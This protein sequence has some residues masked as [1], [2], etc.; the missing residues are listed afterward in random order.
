MGDFVLVEK[1]FSVGLSRPS[2]GTWLSFS[3]LEHPTS[4]WRVVVK[5]KKKK[6]TNKKEKPKNEQ[7]QQLK[8]Y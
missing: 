1:A 8:G 3:W 6:Q 4:L 7:K 2:K 5:E